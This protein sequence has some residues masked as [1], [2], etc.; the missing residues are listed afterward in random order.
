MADGT[1][2][3]GGHTTGMTATLAERILDVLTEHGPTNTLGVWHHLDGPSIYSRQ[4]HSEL[5]GMLSR[6]QV[7]K[8]EDVW[9]VKD[10]PE[11]GR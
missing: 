5:Y 1:S 8:S 9:A 2:S 11:E 6:G 4:V 10:Q 7:T 3:N